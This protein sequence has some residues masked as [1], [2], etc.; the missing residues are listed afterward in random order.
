M[1][2]AE[3]TYLGIIIELLVG[4]YVVESDMYTIVKIKLYN[5]RA[6]K[7]TLFRNIT[8]AHVL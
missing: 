5:L 6:W 3:I 1:A 7:C 2:T 8:W 4:M